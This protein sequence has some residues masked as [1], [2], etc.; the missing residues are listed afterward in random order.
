MPKLHSLRVDPT[1]E[2]EGIW[3]EYVPGF[4]CLIA[5]LN[6]P[7]YE[8]YIRKLKAPELD[9]LRRQDPDF[10]EKVEPFA[11]QAMAHTVLLGWEGLEDDMDPVEEC[12]DNHEY[13][14]LE[15]GR[16]QRM[17][18]YSP[19]KA[20]EFFND[21]RMSDFYTWVRAT[22]S[23]IEQYRERV[24]EDALG[25]SSTTSPGTPDTANTLST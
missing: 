9:G 6:N 10:L 20:L 4:R 15:D 21:P 7:R 5:R 24:T 2:T 3:Q 12:P 18:L 19:D 11:K 14:Q 25:N 22:A 16:F 23:D 1:K 17:I 13:M 8:E